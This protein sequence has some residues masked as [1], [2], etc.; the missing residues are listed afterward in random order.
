MTRSFVE[1]GL[2][3]Q[4]LNDAFYAS[5][6]NASVGDSIKT[7]SNSLRNKEVIRL[8][9]P[10]SSKTSMIHNS[11]SI[12][13]FNS[14][15]G[16]WALPTSLINF[17]GS[18]SPFKNFSVNTGGKTSSL[19][20]GSFFVE[21]HLMHD[22]R[23]QNLSIGDLSVYR[24]PEQDNTPTQ[25]LLEENF[26]LGGENFN[27]DK[28]GEISSQ[29][30]SLSAQRSSKFDA[31]PS[32]TFSANNEYPFLIEKVVVE[33][34]FCFGSG[35]FYDKSTLCTAT[36]SLGDYTLNGSSGMNNAVNIF[37]LYDQ[38]GPALTVT[39]MSQKNY[40][41]GKIR[42]M[43][44]KGV[45]THEE[46]TT[47]EIKLN[48]IFDGYNSTDY[49]YA[50]TVGLNTGSYDSVVSASYS[51]LTR[52]HTGSIKIKSTASITNGCKL[53]DYAGGFISFIVSPQQKFKNLVTRKFS[54]E[55]FKSGNDSI[56]DQ[57]GLIGVDS[58]G[59]GMTGFSPSGG[60]I[61]GGEYT[62][63]NTG[64][65]R[66]DGAMR[67]PFYIEN[68]LDRQALIDYVTQSLQL[69]TRNF[70]TNPLSFYFVSDIFLGAS[71]SSPYLLYPGEK[72]ILSVSKNRPSFRSFKIDVDTVADP[73][74]D[75]YGIPSF[76]SSSFYND[77]RGLQGH[78]VQLSTGSI[79]ITLYG[80]Y[81]RAGN[82][83][84]P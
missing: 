9:F 32:E 76:I 59:R 70:F 64:S 22:F 46:D 14:S 31:S 43:I 11:S 83:Y 84:I 57:V 80:S 67:N 82:S 33:I 41:T 53:I 62:M 49:W 30:Y 3:D 74:A 13:Y 60:S 24:I 78:D 54:E 65:F 37:S 77:M 15:T 8:T 66:L 2:H 12:Y 34:P 26:N 61:F 63:A 20:N 39:L 68:V 7:F 38:G 44:S 42:D 28:Q 47:F 36:S 71:K 45:I 19:A 27:L 79:N 35:W 40:G 21:D 29:N 58:F 18:L 56:S 1:D 10:V 6:S 48:K 25:K 16:T 73:N 81:V 51:G 4:D 17:T 5:G 55:F 75:I 52:F 72:L 50:N 23:G 69:D